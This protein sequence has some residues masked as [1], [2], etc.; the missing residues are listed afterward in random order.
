MPKTLKIALGCGIGAFITFVG[1]KN[2]GIII[3]NS[4]TLVKL[5]DLSYFPTLLAVLGIVLVIVLYVL[6]VPGFILIA[7]GFTALIGFGYNLINPIAGLP[8]FSG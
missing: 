6:R 5:G 1:L 3:E 8:A 2:A 4:V 7:M